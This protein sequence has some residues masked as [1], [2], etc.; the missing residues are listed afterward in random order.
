MSLKVLNKKF[1]SPTLQKKFNEQMISYSKIHHHTILPLYGLSLND[2]CNESRPT[3]FTEYMGNVSINDL[4]K[5]NR[6]FPI[7]KKYLLLLGIAQG[8]KFIHSHQI[9]HGE[10]KP[11]NTLLGQNYHPL[12]N[13]FNYTDITAN[14]DYPN[15]NSENNYNTIIY[16]SPEVLNGKRP[17]KKSDVF[18]F[19][20]MA[21]R[22][23]TN[24]SSYPHIES[25]NTFKSKITNN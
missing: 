25:I 22:L 12:I 6:Q 11:D 19:A 15:N 17:T 1:E 10:L 8:M 16:K 3:I 2:F 18:S 13:D 20:I 9:I 5:R 7:S 21:H 14:D 24:K 4:V 23:I